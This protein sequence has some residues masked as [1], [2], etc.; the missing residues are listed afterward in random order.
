MTEAEPLQRIVLASDNAG[1]LREVQALL[2]GYQILPQSRFAVSTCAETADTFVENALLK[3]RNAAAQSG[4]AAIADDSGLLVDA[5]GGAP[6]VFSARYAGADASDQD[7]VAALLHALA[8]VPE[9]QRSARF[10]C[11]LVYLRHAADPCPIV[12]QGAWEGAISRQPCGHGGFGYDR[13]FW[14]AARGCTCAQLSADEKNAL[15]HR[16][17]AVRQLAALLSTCPQFPIGA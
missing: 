16:G 5:L 4:L 3:A 13:V 12:V 2:L 6:G 9:G 15:S 17:Q 7:N 11:V 8:D 1:K 10:V 14:L